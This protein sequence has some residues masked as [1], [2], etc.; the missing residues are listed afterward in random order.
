MRILN[1]QEYSQAN[2]SGGPTVKDK[3]RIQILC[4]PP[5]SFIMSNN[6]YQIHTDSSYSLSFPKTKLKERI[7]QGTVRDVS[8][9]NRQR[10]RESVLGINAKGFR[11]K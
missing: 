9:K 5:N 3:E 11:T 10:C 1:A 8:W 2:P 4:P 6:T 7:C